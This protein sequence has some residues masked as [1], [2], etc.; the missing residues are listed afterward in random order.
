MRIEKRRL[1]LEFVASWKPVLWCIG[2]AMFAGSKV[3]AFGTL[4][5][6]RGVLTLLK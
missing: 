2:V 4:E 3:W 1:R 5:E 6:R